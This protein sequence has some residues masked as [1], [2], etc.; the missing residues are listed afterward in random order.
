MMWLVLYGL[1]LLSFLLPLLIGKIVQ[2]ESR[3]VGCL[4]RVNKSLNR[5]AFIAV[6]VL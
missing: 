1:G 2:V 6:V 3:E 4:C 5:V